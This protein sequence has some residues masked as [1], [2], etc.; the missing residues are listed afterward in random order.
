MTVCATTGHGVTDMAREATYIESVNLNMEKMIELM[1]HR[2][3]RVFTEEESRVCKLC[4]LH[5]ITFSLNETKRS[6]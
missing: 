5:G 1:E 3:N 6:I 4:F 2:E